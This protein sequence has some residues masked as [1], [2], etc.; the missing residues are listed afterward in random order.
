M[1]K[2][3]TIQ[4][5]GKEYFI[6]YIK[7]IQKETD[8]K[9]RTI[10]SYV[11]SETKDRSNDI[12]RLD[13]L[14][15]EGYKK[16]PI[17]FADHDHT[18]PIGK[19]LWLKIGD[20]DGKKMLIAKTKF[21]STQLGNDRYE[22]HRDGFLNAWSV[23]IIVKA[24]KEF[25]D[26]GWDITESELYEYSSVGVPANPDAVDINKIMDLNISAETKM[27]ILREFG[28]PETKRILA[29]N[30]ILKVGKEQKELEK[31]IKEYCNSIE[32]IE[33]KAT[34]PEQ[35]L[36]GTERLTEILKTLQTLKEE[37]K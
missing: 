32:N 3:K 18:K 6:T 14:K 28:D 37:L 30:E 16:N 8:D 4:I 10:V 27:R 25:D 11:S 9:E 34:E 15:T 24:Y 23:G 33:V 22:L 12:I 19:N 13:G 35:K 21:N 5:D 17:V 26:G 20:V 7:G 2:R 29:I 36:G 31:K 1:D